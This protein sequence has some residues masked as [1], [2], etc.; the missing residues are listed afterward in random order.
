MIR[1][2]MPRK[3]TRASSQIDESQNK[4]HCEE[5]KAR[6]E[7]IFKNQQMDPKKGFTLKKSNYIDFMAHIRQVPETLN[8]E[9]FCEKRPSVDEELVREF[10]VN[11]TSNELTE[12]PVHGIKVLITSNAI[13]EFFKL[14]NFENDEY[15][16]SMSNIEPKNLQEFLKELTVPN[17]KWTMSKQGIHTCQRE[18]LIPLPKVWFYFIQFSLLPSSHGTTISLE[19]MVLL[20]FILTRKT[21]D[22]GKIILREIQNCVVRR[23]GPVYFPFTITILYL[24]A[25]ILTNVKKTGYS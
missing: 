12:V 19:R 10:Y 6:Y 15:F 8:W 21:I 22:V 20:Y 14:P 25:K 11:L 16:S 3:R 5:A 24:K 9:L 7:S 17:S 4:F 2:I 13:N 18:Y 1:L 23:S